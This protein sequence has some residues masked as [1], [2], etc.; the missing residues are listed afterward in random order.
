MTGLLHVSCEGLYPEHLAQHPAFRV[1][2]SSEEQMKEWI[3]LRKRVSGSRET[4]REA[5]AAGRVGTPDTFW[6]QEAAHRREDGTSSAS[7]P[8]LG[9]FEGVSVFLCGPLASSG[10][11]ELSVSGDWTWAFVASGE[12]RFVSH[13]E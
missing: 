7:A 2:S 10:F 9:R 13:Q 12:S 11:R 6:G 8:G 5:E 1:C 4:G 3:S